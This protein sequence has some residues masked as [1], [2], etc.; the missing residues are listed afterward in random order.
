[1]NLS[2]SNASAALFGTFM[3]LE[4]SCT[5]A[6]ACDVAPDGGGGMSAVGFAA[7]SLLRFLPL[8]WAA[9]ADCSSVASLL[10]VPLFLLAA[11]AA[12][13]SACMQQS[14]FPKAHAGEA[15]VEQCT[16]PQQPETNLLSGK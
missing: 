10:V 11:H 3:E 6:I 9:A 5:A 1:V 2:S 16:A 15:Y 4:A 13:L 8:L 12:T 7:P 14:T